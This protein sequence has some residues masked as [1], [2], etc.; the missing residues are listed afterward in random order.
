MAQYV[1]DI[2]TRNPVTVPSEALLTEASR[3][4][5]E[6]D[7]GSVVV[8][9]QDG[10]IGGIVTDRDIVVRAIAQNKDPSRT[11]LGD[12]C[13]RELVTLEPGEK[14]ETAVSLMREKGIRR[15]P[16]QEGGKPVG[17]VSIGDLAIERDPKSALGG[18]SSQAA[19]K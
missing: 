16:V 11:S 3:L 19:N 6:K 1:R 5:G 2:M 10:R 18:I 4:M 8:V 12:I 17:I 14:I 9:K 7:I 15:I 13:S